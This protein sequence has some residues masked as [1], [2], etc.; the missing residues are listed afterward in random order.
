M[1]VKNRS[2]VH[3][4][5]EAFGTVAYVSDR[6]DTFLLDE[7]TTKFVLKISQRWTDVSHEDG[8]IAL[9]LAE[10][11][12]IDARIE[13]N[14][15]TQKSYSGPHLIGSFQDVPVVSIPLLI[16]CFSTSWCPLKCVYCHADDLMKEDYRTRE[17]LDSIERVAH[18]AANLP[19]LVY[20]ITGGDP[21]TR[22]ER[23]LRLAQALKDDAGIVLD[24]SGVGKISDAEI[25]LRARPMHLR[26]SID[27]MDPRINRVTRPINNTIKSKLDLDIVGASSLDYAE[28]MIEE[29]GYLANGISVQTTISSKNDQY[30]HLMILRDWLVSRGVKNWVLHVAIPAGAALRFSSRSDAEKRR[31]S[32]RSLKDQLNAKK[33]NDII[34]D[35]DDATKAIRRLIQATERDGTAIDIRCTDANLAPNSVFLIG[36][37]GDL[38][39]QGVGAQNGRKVQ[40][41]AYG[42]MPI[43]TASLWSYV[44]QSHHVQRY[45][46]YVPMIHGQL[47]NGGFFNR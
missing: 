34:P 9:R 6:D 11:G 4:R 41:S 13:S 33:S 10:L 12:V 38:F 46:N 36:S 7:L 2:L 21:L 25:L 20:V 14:T 15:I 30:D 32:E 1:K 24:T 45:I 31:I 23:A 39:T 22:P 40:I 42:A 43:N 29:I 37:E 26:I 28:R 35:R 8:H 18:T 47:I 17:D 19:A 5:N 3:L 44:S 27:S 16:N